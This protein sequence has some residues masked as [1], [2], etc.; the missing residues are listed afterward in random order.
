M[1][2]AQHQSFHIRDGW[3]K[4]G[5]EEVKKD[6]GIFLDSEAYLK[7]GLG[8]NMVTALRFWMVATGL[9]EEISNQKR[10][11]GQRLTHLGKLI[12][13]KDPY[14][15]DDGTLWLI[16]YNI[17]K[18]KDEATAWYWFFNRFN[19]QSFDRD[20]FVKELLA[21]NTTDRNKDIATASLEKD[22]DCFI[23]TYMPR[24]K[25]SSPEDT[26][27]SPLANLKLLNV[28]V[29]DKQK[30]YYLNRPEPKLI[31]PLILLYVIKKYQEEKQMDEKTNK[32]VSQLSLRDLLA[33]E[34]SPG[35]IFILGMRLAEAI[36]QANESHPEFAFRFTRTNGLDVLTVPPVKAEDIL[37]QHYLNYSYL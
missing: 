33:S 30:K 14:F 11:H 10:S 36:R 32:I 27:E 26:L 35:R 34:C 22:F 12:L 6:E 7:L 5:L 13:E 1:G 23:K 17:V 9:T 15:E 8:K 28:D 3:L 20:L 31:P 25:N 24:E 4:K 21:W 2:F 19:R 18:N 37:N 16:H 29:S